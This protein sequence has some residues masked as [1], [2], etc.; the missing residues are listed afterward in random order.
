MCAGNKARQ[1]LISLI[2]QLHAVEMLEYHDKNWLHHDPKVRS[3][4]KRDIHIRILYLLTN[5]TLDVDNIKKGEPK[6]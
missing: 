4:M 6:Q 3:E 1:T 2:E 5:S